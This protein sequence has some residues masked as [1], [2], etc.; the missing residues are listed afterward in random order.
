MAR[1]RTTRMVVS[2]V[3][4]RRQPSRGPISCKSR[5]P[6]RFPGP[7]CP[8]GRA[9]VSRVRR[10]KICRLSAELGRDRWA[11]VGS[12][13]SRE[14]SPGPIEVGH[15][16]QPPGTDGGVAP[17]EPPRDR[18]RCWEGL[19][20]SLARHRSR[21]VPGA[22]GS[23]RPSSS[24]LPPEIGRKGRG[25][26]ASRLTPR[27]QIATLDRSVLSSRRPTRALLRRRVSAY[28]FGIDPPS[29]RSD[30]TTGGNR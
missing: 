23:G 17:R 30:D 27:A 6:R 16:W 18:W 4:V 10:W 12:G 13:Y 2:G 5:A 3:S 26:E 1:R 11:V 29:L 9:R 25:R 14:P 28:S 7:I 22:P 20:G 24:F 8:A 15:G 21:C 19:R